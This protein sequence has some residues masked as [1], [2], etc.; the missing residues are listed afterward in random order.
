MLSVGTH[1]LGLFK[2]EL[3]FD[4][5][6]NLCQSIVNSYLTSPLW[7][8]FASASYVGSL[9]S[10]SS[11]CF[12]LWFSNQ[13][14]TVMDGNVSPAAVSSRHPKTRID[15]DQP[16]FYCSIGKGSSSAL[17]EGKNS[18]CSHIPFPP[19]AHKRNPYCVQQFS[20]ALHTPSQPDSAS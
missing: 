13:K 3:I 17:I 12:V 1:K 9:R 7:K 10:S 14:E 20:S 6:S 11:R 8:V 15:Y 4:S 16:Q 18:R 2:I 5:R 19:G